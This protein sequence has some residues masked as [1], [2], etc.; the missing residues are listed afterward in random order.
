MQGIRTGL[1]RNRQEAREHLEKL[2]RMGIASD[3][4]ARLSFLYDNLNILDSKASSLL[5]F[6]G[7]LLAALAIWLNALPRNLFHLVLDLIFVV[8]LVSCTLCLRI[9]WM[10]WVGSGDLDAPEDH[11]QSLVLRRDERTIFYRLAWWLSIVSVA[12][13]TV[14]AGYHTLETYLDMMK[15]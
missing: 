7:V 10:Y 5:T 14:A 2:E 3:Y 1:H 15:G 4:A 9:V 12:L 6:N 11:A 13:T 8:L